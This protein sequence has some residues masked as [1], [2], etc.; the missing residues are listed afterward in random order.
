[1]PSA[2]TQRPGGGAPAHYFPC[3]GGVGVGGLSERPLAL[4]ER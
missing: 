3:A 4:S 2:G 1:M